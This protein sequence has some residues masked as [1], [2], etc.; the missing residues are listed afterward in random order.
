M[1]K[2]FVLE[3]AETLSK[4]QDRF[5]P[6]T[7]VS[8]GIFLAMAAKKRLLR[9]SHKGSDTGPFHLADFITR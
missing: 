2:S 7:K 6:K 5:P 3:P 1:K 4:R 9:Q 8:A